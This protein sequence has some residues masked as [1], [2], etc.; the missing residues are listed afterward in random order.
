MQARHTKLVAR[1]R[2][3][4]LAATYTTVTGVCAQR[5][6]SFETPP[7]SNHRSRPKPWEG[8]YRCSCAG[9]RLVVGEG[10][11][12]TFAGGLLKADFFAAVSSCFGRQIPD[13]VIS[14]R[15]QKVDYANRYQNRVEA[16]RKYMTAKPLKCSPHSRA[17]HR[18][19]IRR[20]NHRRQMPLPR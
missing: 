6:I 13:Q 16:L 19:S 15:H 10:R 4:R 5:N 14:E 12:I 3:C 8:D 9:G 2:R 17:V 1:R 18:Q 7:T 11:V 20:R